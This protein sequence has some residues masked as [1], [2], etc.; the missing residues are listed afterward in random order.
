MS[1]EHPY[2][3]YAYLEVDPETNE[4]RWFGTKGMGVGYVH[5]DRAAEEVAAAV[6]AEREACA[7][8]AREYA[9]CYAEGSDGRNTFILLAEWIERRASG[10]NPTP[11]GRAPD[12]GLH[13]L[14]DRPG[15]KDR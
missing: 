6:A 7:K 8:M 3:D 4:K 14:E 13:D 9:R 15:R 12:N 11:R 5:E 2:P 1:L 10:E